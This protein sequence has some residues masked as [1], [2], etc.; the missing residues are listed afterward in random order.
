MVRSVQL[1]TCSLISTYNAK[2]IYEK[3]PAGN[4]AFP[5]EF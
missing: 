3:F 5:V 2:I 1:S 4:R